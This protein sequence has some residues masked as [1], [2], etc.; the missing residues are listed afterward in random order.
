[1]RVERISDTKVRIFISY[2]DLEERGIGR[3]EIWQNGRKI[4]EL[5]W[6]IMEKAYVEVGFEVVGPIAVEAFTMPTE[7]VVVV[8]SQV[9]SVI[10]EEDDDHDDSGLAIED[11]GQDTAELC[12][13]F[14]D[15]EDV[16]RA[17][18]ALRPRL[19]T[20]GR[21]FAYN[22]RFYLHFPA[23][24]M[25]PAEQESVA[26]VAE[27]YGERSRTTVAVLEEYGTVVLGENAVEELCRKF[28]LKPGF[29]E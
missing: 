22:A 13:T 27:E 21:L 2:E 29:S 24:D 5:F 7:G 17:A 6:D 15:F 8:V 28:P 16:V 25:D 10:D 3:D 18:H 19:S 1:M 20:G 26:A 14:Q 23:K 11:D 9:P 4:Q 12:F